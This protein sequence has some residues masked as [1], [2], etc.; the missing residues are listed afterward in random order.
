MTK[1][2]DLWTKVNLLI[3]LSKNPVVDGR[4]KHYRCE[5][6]FPT[7]FIFVPTQDCIKHKHTYKEILLTNSTLTLLNNATCSY[8]IKYYH[9]QSPINFSVESSTGEFIQKIQ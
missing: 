2:A 9:R 8:L 3:K 4:S 1:E 6:T 5:I 7:N